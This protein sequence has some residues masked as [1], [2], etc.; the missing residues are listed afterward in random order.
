[1]LF[2]IG[3]TTSQEKIST[4]LRMRLLQVQKEKD[5]QKKQIPQIQIPATNLHRHV[6][7]LEFYITTD[8]VHW[9]V[10]IPLYSSS[11][12]S[13]SSYSCYYYIVWYRLLTHL[14]TNRKLYSW[15]EVFRISL[16]D[17]L[18]NFHFK[19]FPG[20]S[21]ASQNSHVPLLLLPLPRT[22]FITTIITLHIHR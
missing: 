8:I 3:R 21:M 10:D 17:I 14:V 18:F 13:S 15:H 7:T 19:T 5:T 11:S 1:M 12:S 20:Q 16:C 2:L 22:E 6:L 4:S 9:T